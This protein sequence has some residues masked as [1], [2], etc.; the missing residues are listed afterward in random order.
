MSSP[1]YLA[2]RRDP[3]AAAA[4]RAGPPG[5]AAATLH[6]VAIRT[7]VL[8]RCIAI[9]Y[10]AAQVAIWHT[11]FAAQPGRLAGPLAAAG[12]AA[13]VAALL[14]RGLA[15]A[16]LAGADSA[17]CVLLALAAGWCVPPA[18]RGDT[19]SWL[20]I[21][22]AA[23]LVVPAWFTPPRLAG[24][25]ALASAAAFWA[26]SMLTRPPGGTSPAPAAALLLTVAVLV[27]WGY[28][29]L[30]RRAARADAALARA[31]RESREQYVVLSRSAERREHERLLHDTVLNTLTALARLGSG[32]AGDV[33]GRCR[34]DVALVEHVLGAAGAPAAAGQLP[35]GGLR[36]G[37]A[38]VATEMRRR[39][40][41][42][43]VGDAASDRAGPALPPAAS[44]ALTHAVREALANVLSHAGTGEAWVNVALVPGAGRP[45]SSGAR[46][47]GLRVT[48][49]DAGP[50]FDPA[51]VGPA[52]LGL[53]RSI[54]ERVADAGGRASVRSAAGLGTV[55]CLEWPAGQGGLP[56]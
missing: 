9:G 17:V 33:T 14:R 37:L 38:A 53:R 16:P 25:L 50:G 13:A 55:V 45:G 11:F 54:I 46:P 36:A 44:A 23:Q 47:A 15:T 29:V 12:S 26:G 51:R 4:T 30:Q 21:A 1:G 42:V 8:I 52:R 39:G 34:H 43:H 3:G 5:P 20:Y 10:V 2:R 32:P 27:W 48:V 6:T 35:L 28:Q 49:R 31:D 7:A 41:V 18:M 22:L 56:C 40:L 19:A 24:P